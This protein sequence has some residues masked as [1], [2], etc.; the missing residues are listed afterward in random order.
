[1]ENVFQCKKTET[2]VTLVWMQGR[3]E[4]QEFFSFPDLEEMRIKGTDLIA[5]P[6]LF[7]IDVQEHKIYLSQKGRST[8]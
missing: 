8:N 7:R 4:N 5:H 6:E 2:G 3:R 1:M